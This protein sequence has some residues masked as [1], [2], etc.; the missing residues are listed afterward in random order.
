M[1]CACHYMMASWCK[2]QRL[3]GSVVAGFFILNYCFLLQLSAIHRKCA[4]FSNILNMK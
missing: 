3:M 2:L 1:M 4:S